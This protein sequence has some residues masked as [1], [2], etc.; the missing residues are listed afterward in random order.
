MGRFGIFE[1]ALIVCAICL[2]FG[3]KKLP[4]IGKAF[5]RALKQFRNAVKDVEDDGSSKKE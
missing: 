3:S 1:I 2:L 5:G 4:E